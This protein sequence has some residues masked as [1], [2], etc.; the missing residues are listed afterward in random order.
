[1][2]LASETL[3]QINQEI[4]D[5]CSSTVVRPTV[6]G[7]RQARG[8]HRRSSREG[9]VRRCRI[10]YHPDLRYRHC[11]IVIRPVESIRHNPVNRST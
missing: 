1:M 7:G 3:R 11:I 9:T 2:S 8:T 6:V 10:R 4:D 5:P